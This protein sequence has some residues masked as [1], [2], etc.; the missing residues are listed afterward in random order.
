D[1]LKLKPINI[2]K[3]VSNIPYNIS[4]LIIEKLLRNI[5]SVKQYL[6]YKKNLD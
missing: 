1:F 2:D 6:D 4:S 3:I 5:S